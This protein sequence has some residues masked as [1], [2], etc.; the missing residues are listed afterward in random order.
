[1]ARNKAKSQFFQSSDGVDVF[2]WHH[3]VCGDGDDD[4]DGG[5]DFS[6]PRYLK[7]H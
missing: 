5:G 2:L 4:G 7:R 1:M 6:F 3:G